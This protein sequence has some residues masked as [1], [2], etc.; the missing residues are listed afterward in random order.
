MAVVD[1]AAPVKR[2]VRPNVP[3]NIVGGFGLSLVAALVLAGMIRLAF[4]AMARS[5]VPKVPKPVI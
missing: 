3:L 4:R 1:M 2:P 5:P